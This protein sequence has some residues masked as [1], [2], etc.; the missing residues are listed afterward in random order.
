MACATC[1][2]KSCITGPGGSCA[3]HGLDVQ[4][5][6]GP[7]FA[8]SGPQRASS[9]YAIPPAFTAETRHYA[10]N[11][12][13]DGSQGPSGGPVKSAPSGQ[14]QSRSMGQLPYNPTQLL[15]QMGL[16]PAQW[17]ALSNSQKNAKLYLLVRTPGEVTKAGQWVEAF[18]QLWLQK[19]QEDAQMAAG[20]RDARNIMDATTTPPFARPMNPAG[21]AQRHGMRAIFGNPYVAPKP[22]GQSIYPS[23]TQYP[24]GVGNTTT[25]PL[26]GNPF[27][28]PLGNPLGVQPIAPN[29]LTAQIMANSNNN[30]PLYLIGAVVIG[31]MIWMASQD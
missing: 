30:L 3:L 11:P 15:N 14:A 7:V 19:Q 20:S 4:P 10:A 2:K 21:H 28:N 8:R 1:G 22:A 31:G 6:R 5:T 9:S 29:P 16:T 17:L 27:G 24:G 25:N 23:Q 13:T 18:A 12:G 26:F